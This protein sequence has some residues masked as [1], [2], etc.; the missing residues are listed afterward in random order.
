MIKG[1]NI[2]LRAIEPADL[3]HLYEWEN[4]ASSWPVSNT[5][6]PFSKH[7]LQQYLDTAHLDIY[8]TRQLRL[9]I[10]T[11]DDRAVGC[12]DLFDFDPNHRRAGVGILIAG[13]PDRQKGFASEALGLLIDYCFSTLH[14]R[15]LY[16][17]ILSD[18]EASIRL[19]KKHNFEIT[20][21]KKQWIRVGNEWRDEH[22][23]Q[24][25]KE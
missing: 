24:L 21:T 22:L 9:V 17:N 13:E 25:V 15:Q 23:L 8:S 10:C 6:A 18:N 19:F 7:V 20:G 3:D 12:I 14:L 5:L 4:D 2:Y 11:Y 16:C 1:Q